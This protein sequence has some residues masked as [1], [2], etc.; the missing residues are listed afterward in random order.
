MQG[1]SVSKSELHGLDGP[2]VYHI[3][4]FI[5][6]STGEEEEQKVWEHASVM[7]LEFCV[8][9]T[10]TH[11]EKSKADVTLPKPTSEYS[12]LMLFFQ[13]HTWRASYLDLK[14]TQPIHHLQNPIMDLQ[15]AVSSGSTANISAAKP[16]KKAGRYSYT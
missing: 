11:A 13:K 12:N 8:D 1:C 6:F 2:A 15:A 7:E 4:V 3:H 10:D 16:A 9:Y 5:Q 14:Q